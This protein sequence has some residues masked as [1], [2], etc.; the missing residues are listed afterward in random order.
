MKEKELLKDL[1]TVI[2]KHSVD[3]FLNLSDF[4]IAEYLLDSIKSLTKLNNTKDE[5]HIEDAFIERMYALY[6]TKCPKRGTTLGKSHKDK[7]RIRKLLKQYSMEEI[8]TVFK[9]EIEEK[10]EK[11]YMQNFSTFLNNFPD[12]N[13]EQGT[14]LF[15]TEAKSDDKLIIGGTVYR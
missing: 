7:E 13:N 1:S 2:N 8:E 15:E 5:A 11:H 3:S 9:R 10:Y 12:P 4:V 6:P 14:L